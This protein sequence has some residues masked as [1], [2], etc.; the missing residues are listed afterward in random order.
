[1][2]E[3]NLSFCYTLDAIAGGSGEFNRKLREIAKEKGYK[4]NEKKMI[5]TSSNK[6]VENLGSEKEILEFLGVNYFEPQD[7]TDSALG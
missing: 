1:M 6:N 3:N 5:S 7:R 2:L 4:L